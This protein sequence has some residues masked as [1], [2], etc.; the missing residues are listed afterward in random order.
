M[1]GWNMMMHDWCPIAHTFDPTIE[2]IDRVTLCHT[3]IFV[4]RIPA[5]KRESL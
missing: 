5:G 2:N 1:S 3:G 4:D